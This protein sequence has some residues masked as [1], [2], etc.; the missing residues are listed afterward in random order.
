MTPVQF[1]APVELLY[2]AAKAGT[3][4]M[5]TILLQPKMAQFPVAVVVGLT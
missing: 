4:G 2:L 5:A 1:V 3:V